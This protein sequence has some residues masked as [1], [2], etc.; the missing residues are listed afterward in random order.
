MN[1]NFLGDVYLD[2]SYSVKISLEHYIFNLE[3]PLSIAGIPALSK[4]NLGQSRSYIEGT[5]NKMPVAVNLANN[6]IMDYG[7]AAFDYTIKYLEDKNIKYFGAGT[8]ANNYNNL[9]RMNLFLLHTH[10]KNI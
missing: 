5:F 4:I 10:R 6:H 2:K 3:Y 7:E 8:K 1:I 9:A